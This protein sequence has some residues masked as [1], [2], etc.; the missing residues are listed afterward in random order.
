MKVGI[1]GLGRMGSALAGRLV[2]QQCD[3]AVWNRSATPLKEPL[4]S[5]VT[6]V[7]APA[8]LWDHCDIVVTSLKDDHALLDV[9]LG[10]GGLLCPKAEGKIAIDT[11]TVLP[12]TVR[13]LSDKGKAYGCHVLDSPVLGT[14][15]PAR[16]GQLIAMVGGDEQAVECVR[17]LLQKLTRK[18]CYLGP[19]GSGA[20]MKLSVNIPMSAY[21]AALSDSLAL[22]VHHGI[23]PQE[24]IDILADSPAALAQLRLKRGV[25]AGTDRQVGFSIDGVIKDLN[26]IRAA[27]GQALTLPV[28]EATAQTYRSASKT[29]AGAEDVAA[30]ALFRSAAP[31]VS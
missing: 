8:A 10:A 12:A 1:A 27:A 30:V 13:R 22:A 18:I 6:R 24:V 20:A 16:S 11:S 26:V 5:A 31:T 19:S 14:S 3:L 15:T 17:P 25:L 7:E 23:A 9:Y 4:A 29:G 28:V 21:W 2:D